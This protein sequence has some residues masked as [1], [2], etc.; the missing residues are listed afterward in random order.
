MS[1][2]GETSSDISI[3]VEDSIVNATAIMA[4]SLRWSPS[5]DTMGFQRVHITQVTS[6]PTKLSL[7]FCWAA[8]IVA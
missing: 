2:F 8:R 6:D 3:L 4:Y 1:F 5:R 7:G